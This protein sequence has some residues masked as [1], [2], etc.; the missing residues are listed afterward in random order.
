MPPEFPRLHDRARDDLGAL[1]ARLQ[2]EPHSGPL[3]VPESGRRMRRKGEH[4]RLQPL[5]VVLRLFRNAETLLQAA[6]AVVLVLI[7]SAV[8]IHTVAHLTLTGNGFLAGVLNAINGV[9]L[10]VIIL[11]ILRTVLAHFTEEDFPLHDFLI[12]GIISAT[13][14]ILT[15]A[16]RLTVSQASRAS[17][18]MSLLEVLASAGVVLALVVALFVV[19]R[20]GPIERP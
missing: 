12:I 20:S 3:T 1:L 19:S 11:E 14:H 5:G 7:A 10:V 4:V 8:L 2:T 9:L 15:V 13:R 18:T 17:V 6:V 16:V